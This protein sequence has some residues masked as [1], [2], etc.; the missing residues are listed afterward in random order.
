LRS[1]SGVFRNLL[2]RTLATL[3]N[4]TLIEILVLLAITSVLVA[5]WMPAVQTGGRR[6][7]ARRQRCRENLQRIGLALHAYHD[8]H[9]SFPPVY[10]VNAEGRRL[11]SWRTLI[12]PYLDG[13]AVFQRVDLDKPW[14]DPA[15]AEPRKFVPLMYACAAAQAEPGR[16]TYMGVAVPGG[17]FAPGKTTKLAEITDGS[18]H[19]LMVVEVPAV[20]S[21]HWMDPTDLDSASLAALAKDTKTTHPL[22]LHALFADGSRRFVTL[23]E[24]TR[25]GRAWTTIAGG[26]PPE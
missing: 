20:R 9:G 23:E 3:R 26:E 13:K 10:T 21:V 5:L 25:H 16:T 24:L 8:D 12:L 19:T 11:H 22:G 18:A 15:N 17:V 2:R 1:T 14:D 6:G 7:E 4:L